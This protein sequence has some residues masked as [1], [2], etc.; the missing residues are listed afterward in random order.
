MPPPAPTPAER[1]DALVAELGF[2]DD[3]RETLALIVERRLGVRGLP[4][5]RQDLDRRVRGCVSAVWVEAEEVDG[6]LHWWTAADSP[7]VSALV[8]LVTE[9]YEGA[10]AVDALAHDTRILERL[11]LD[12]ALSFTRIE[13]IAAV[14][15]RIK[16][17]AAAAILQVE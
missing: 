1:E 15:Q 5:E 13:G 16:S 7:M 10:S 9:V 3:P 6:R 2:L 8:A 17:L 11:R 4:K 12:R 14:R